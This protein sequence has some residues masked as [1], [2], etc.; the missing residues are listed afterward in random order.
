MEPF[1]SFGQHSCAANGIE[2]PECNELVS[3]HAFDNGVSHG[4]IAAFITYV[5]PEDIL[6]FSREDIDG[7][8]IS[9]YPGSEASGFEKSE[10][11][12]IKMISGNEPPVQDAWR[13]DFWENGWRAFYRPA[14]DDERELQINQFCSEELSGILLLGMEIH[15]D[16]EAVRGAVDSAELRTDRFSLS[17]E[18]PYV[19]QVDALVSMV[20]VAI[21][22]EHVLTWLQKVDEFQF[23][24][25]TTE[26]YTPIAGSG[27]LEGSRK[28]LIFAANN[29]VY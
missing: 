28:N 14:G 12:V 29:C 21:P 7:W 2:D 27:R 24:I 25:N 17:Y 10:P 9:H 1:G 3:Q 22:T 26:G 11:R 5:P 23:W 6:W 19:F 16:E 20:T 18:N 4:S 15:G 13:L 8:G